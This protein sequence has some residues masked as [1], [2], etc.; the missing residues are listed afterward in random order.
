[1][2]TVRC[3]G[4]ACSPLPRM[5]PHYHAYNC[6]HTCPLPC[7]PPCHSCPLPCTPLLCIPPL[8]CMP[9]AMHVPHHTHPLPCMPP[10]RTHP[11]PHTHPTMHASC[12][13]HPLPHMLPMDRILDTRLWKHYLSATTVADGKYRYICQR[14]L[15]ASYSVTT[16]FFTVWHVPWCWRCKRTIKSSCPEKMTI[17]LK[18]SPMIPRFL[19]IWSKSVLAQQCVALNR[20]MYN[21]NKNYLKCRSMSPFIKSE[22]TYNS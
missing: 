9:L 22:I 17:L 16:P 5:H 2:R 18:W 8:P 10:Y 14:Y 4:H 13:T 1:M 11:V 21:G 12:H 7:I 6:C 3:S 20:N 15:F 19:D